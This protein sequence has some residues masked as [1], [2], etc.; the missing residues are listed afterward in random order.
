M[1]LSSFPGSQI[2]EIL[3]NT[4]K[5][6]K[7]EICKPLYY[8][9]K[10]NKE[11]LNLDLLHCLTPKNWMENMVWKSLQSAFKIIS[12]NRMQEHNM[13]NDKYYWTLK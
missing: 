9:I 12:E 4:M 3:H 7:Q 8:S 2:E 13:L 5:D 10:S 11:N 1:L 6:Y